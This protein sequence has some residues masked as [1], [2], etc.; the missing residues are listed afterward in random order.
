MGYDI[1]LEKQKDYLL[2][3]LGGEANNVDDVMLLANTVLKAAKQHNYT[4]ILFDERKVTLNLDQHDVY[5]CTEELGTFLPS[6]GICVAAVHN[7]KDVII[8]QCFETMLQNR[9][10]NYRI[11]ETI[12]E[13][14]KWLVAKGS[15]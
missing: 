4:N 1:E 12:E 10:I 15:N 14:E 2:V 7:A 5:N 11:F 6:E 13:A 8:F 3:S 9:S